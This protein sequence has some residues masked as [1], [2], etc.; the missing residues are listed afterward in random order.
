MFPGAGRGF[1]AGLRGALAEAEV[2]CQVIP[3]PV[4]A[5]AV[6]DQV[7]DH[8]QRL[9]LQH[10]PHVVTG[11][12]GS[13]LL[14]H[15]H[16][17]F[18]DARTPFIV[19]DLGADPLMTGGSRSPF[20]FSNSFKLWQSMYALG[21]WAATHIGRRAAVAAAF[22]EAGYGIVNA[23]WLGFCEAGGGEVIATEVTHRTT[24]DDD[25][26]EQVRRLRGLEPD[27]VM[28]FYAGRE[29]VSFANAWAALGC[30][31]RIPLLASPLMTH[32]Y[33][34]PQMPV[35]AID[36]MRTAFSWDITARKDRLAE[37]RE[38]SGVTLDEEPAVFTLLGYETG[39]LLAAAAGRAGGTPSRGDGWRDALSGVAIDSPRG[40]VRFDEATGE[41]ATR[42]TLQQWGRA[43]DGVPAPSTLSELS[44]PPTFDEAYAS[45][46]RNDT[47]SGW[48]NPYLVT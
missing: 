45:V 19:N 31:G 35:E 30:A 13:G 37:F 9:L 20:V 21:F 47:R 17:L 34:L 26:A 42:D 39:L 6:K 5:C 23:F 40:D 22:H 14:R 1:L 28:A 43:D 29:G 44:L 12:M 25:P 27:L 46:N 33:W 36:G 48:F 16:S 4:G 7:I 38:T 3:E 2:E 8:I 10:D 32:R 18:I 15:T 11:I 41:V 24:A